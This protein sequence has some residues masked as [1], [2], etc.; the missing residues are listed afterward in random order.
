MNFAPGTGLVGW[1]I[2]SDRVTSVNMM[3]Q[4]LH[5]MYKNT[6]ILLSCSQCVSEFCWL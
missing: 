5:V 1:L 6:A 2:F 3:D 4:L